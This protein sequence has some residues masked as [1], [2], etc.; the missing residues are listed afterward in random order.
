MT[1]IK[2]VNKPRSR[3]RRL[4]R[5]RVARKDDI[6][7]GPAGAFTGLI[8]LGTVSNA[9]KYGL[10]GTDR[11]LRSTSAPEDIYLTETGKPSVLVESVMD[12]YYFGTDTDLP[13]SQFIKQF[14]PKS[15]AIIDNNYDNDTIAYLLNDGGIIYYDRVDKE[16]Y[17]GNEDLEIEASEEFRRDGYDVG[18][19]QSLVRGMERIEI[20]ES[21]RGLTQSQKRVIQREQ[22]RM[23]RYI[24]DVPPEDQYLA[25]R[26]PE[27]A[28]IYTPSYILSGIN[29]DAEYHESVLRR[30]QDDITRSLDRMGSVNS[31]L[32][33]LGKE[34]QDESYLNI[35][36]NN[37]NSVYNNLKMLEYITPDDDDSGHKFIKENYIEFNDLR[38]ADKSGGFIRDVLLNNDDNDNDNEIITAESM[39]KNIDREQYGENTRGLSPSQRR[40]LQRER[41]RRDRFNIPE[42]QYFN[43]L[44]END[45]ND[46]EK[47][48]Y[49]SEQ[50]GKIDRVS[51][52]RLSESA[53]YSN[54]T[55]EDVYLL[56][57]GVV[58]PQAQQNLDSVVERYGQ[59]ALEIHQDD[60]KFEDV[61]FTFENNLATYVDFEPGGEP[62][63]TIAFI[64]KDGS[65]AYRD[66]DDYGSFSGGT[67]TRER[68]LELE[69]KDLKRKKEFPEEIQI[70]PSDEYVELRE[71]YNP[72]FHIDQYGKFEDSGL[73]Y[74]RIYDYLE[75]SSKTPLQDQYFQE[76]NYNDLRS[77]ALRDNSA[78][79]DQYFVPSYN[80]DEVFMESYEL[81][82]EYLSKHINANNRYI[83]FYQNLLNDTEDL[84]IG[85]EEIRR[86]ITD[87]TKK[88]NELLPEAKK[89]GLSEL[90]IE[91]YGSDFDN[92][93]DDEYKDEIYNF[94]SD[95]EI[96]NLSNS[97]LGR[98]IKAIAIDIDLEK[99][100]IQDVQDNIY[101]SSL[102]SEEILQMSSGGHVELSKDSH[103]IRNIRQLETYLEKLVG[104]HSSRKL[105]GR[106]ED[107][108][109]DVLLTKIQNQKDN[110]KSIS[111]MIEDNLNNYSSDRINKLAQDRNEYIK[112]LYDLVNQRK[113]QLKDDSNYA[114]DFENDILESIKSIEY[115][116]IREKHSDNIDN[117]ILLRDKPYISRILQFHDDSFIY[118]Q[119]KDNDLQSY[120]I[121]SGEEINFIYETINEQNER[122]YSADT[123]TYFKNKDVLD[124]LDRVYDSRIDN[125]DLIDFSTV[126]ASNRELSPEGKQIEQQLRLQKELTGGSE[127][128]YDDYDDID[129]ESGDVPETDEELDRYFDEPEPLDAELRTS[130]PKLPS[131][132]TDEEKIE[133]LQVMLNDISIRLEQEKDSE[134]PDGVFVRGLENEQQNI[135]ER[136]RRLVNTL[137]EEP[138]IFY[139]KLREIDPLV[140][141]GYSDEQLYN[142]QL[143]VNEQ[144]REQK[145]LINEIEREHGSEVLSENHPVVEKQYALEELLNV[146][147]DE[148]FT[149]QT[150]ESKQERRREFDELDFG[151]N[152]ERTQIYEQTNDTPDAINTRGMTTSQRRALQR[153]RR[154]QERLS[155]PPEDQYFNE[156][157]EDDD[158]DEQYYSESALNNDEKRI[159]VDKVLN[160]TDNENQVLYDEYYGKLEKLEETDYGGNNS[161]DIERILE[162]LKIIKNPNE[163]SI[164]DKETIAYFDRFADIVNYNDSTLEAGVDQILESIESV[165][166]RIVSMPSSYSGKI[167]QEYLIHED[168]LY[169]S[170]DD[171]LEEYGRRGLD[172]KNIRNKI[173]EFIT[174]QNKSGTSRIRL[175]REPAHMGIKTSEVVENISNTRGL[176]RDQKRALQRER[177]RQQRLSAPPEDQYYNSDFNDDN[178]NE[179]ESEVRR[180]EREILASSTDY[181]PVPK[182]SKNELIRLPD[183]EIEDNIFYELRNIEHIVREIQDIKKDIIS[184]ETLSKLD[185]LYDNSIIKRNN[186]YE[187]KDP[188][189]INSEIEKI[190]DDV[191]LPENIDELHELYVK[192]LE[193][194]TNL[195]LHSNEEYDRKNLALDLNK[196][197]QSSKISGD[198]LSIPPEDQYLSENIEE[199][200]FERLARIN[201]SDFYNL[202][203]YPEFKYDT[204][205]EK[206]YNDIELFAITRALKNAIK[207]L[208]NDDLDEDYSD[209]QQ[210]YELEFTLDK[211]SDER[212]R[213]DDEK[214]MAIPDD[215][216][217]MGELKR[218]IAIASR[219]REEALFINDPDDE[220][221]KGIEHAEERAAYDLE[222]LIQKEEEEINRTHI[223]IPNVEKTRGLTRDQRRALQRERMRQQRLST[224]PEDQYLTD[225]DGDKD[226]D[227]IFSL[228]GIS[229]EPNKN[230]DSL[231]SEMSGQSY[232]EDYKEIKNKLPR[233][234]KERNADNDM[235]MSYIA[236]NRLAKR[237]EQSESIKRP[238]VINGN[239]MMNN[240]R[241]LFNNKRGRN[242]LDKY[243]YAPQMEQMTVRDKPDNMILSHG[244]AAQARK[245]ARV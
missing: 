165:S 114:I 193:S 35:I 188:E 187:L 10:K 28:K 41:T 174:I 197:I 72:R 8:A 177:M 144:I 38:Y 63:G 108:D 206:E 59:K 121:D 186:I 68:I 220:F 57:Y 239:K 29:Q 172:S 82:D 15:R 50:S 244:V 158:D 90:E 86:N 219:M 33:S 222:K 207:D 64:Y 9:L 146:Y 152:V 60:S 233:R 184:R 88:L 13:P 117:I 175:E 25:L 145:E 6:Y 85:E 16:F 112:E 22:R 245:S 203:D 149:R 204:G 14:N 232:K 107:I 99:E 155:T 21:T 62:P 134:V 95:N 138:D 141:K 216:G 103:T 156:D 47:Q 129:L 36:E 96:I 200:F 30:I 77:Y 110:I 126:T 171:I 75:D 17:I 18:P 109:D 231:V 76:D 78:P 137:R 23:S 163:V 32:R 101:G 201:N 243:D 5:A 81:P 194:K 180:R 46:S 53:Y 198:K 40:A 118:V 19:I 179:Y 61:F 94:L 71:K 104:E 67:A 150:E 221:I 97:E 128:E 140:I 89:R 83:E 122:G 91:Q 224:P 176:T 116:R 164:S 227:N 183:D 235:I 34:Q 218:R 238:G 12:Q 168:D 210:L 37:S 69:I 209:N 142:K 127:Y 240:G 161:Y 185:N 236:R 52:P 182:V 3:A 170:L 66:L 237:L 143:E 230:V 132:D 213:R 7:A 20:P 181:Y 148:Y 190:K 54:S 223:E 160:N 58:G 234:N 159:Y 92:K 79:E 211:Y 130:R 42:D 226:G 162:I 205:K 167:K 2:S 154:R 208:Q 26:E 189:Y 45:I 44:S 51:A 133:Y 106:H 49:I 228:I 55:P 24:S 111:K 98:K 123:K 65:V 157:D 191:Y 105:E 102:S 87:I 229:I 31:V 131:E 1:T 93:Y 192:L 136:I 217:E 124:K 139:P 242:N 4:R 214:R 27:Q 196:R 135:S 169:A 125:T 56:E 73:K 166:N 178:D 153:E 151:N 115:E 84:P 119:E 113:N 80:D 74:S 100:S 212:R 39:I 43:N 202:K 195:T 225:K 199:N 120:V 241:N 70:G 173:N 11:S 215:P 48:Q 147:T